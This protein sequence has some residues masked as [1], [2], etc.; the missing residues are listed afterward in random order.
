MDLKDNIALTPV[1]TS[2]VDG[3]AMSRTGIDNLPVKLLVEIFGYTSGV[4]GSFVDDQST[5][6][7]V[8]KLHNMAQVCRRW[9]EIIKDAAKLWAFVMDRT[10][11]YASLVLKQSQ[12]HAFSLSITSCP[13][14]M[15]LYTAVLSHSH[16]WIQADIRLT[17]PNQE[18]SH[19]LEAVSA[20]MLWHLK[21]VSPAWNKNTVIT[22]DLFLD[23]P[24][25]LTSLTLVGISI[26]RWN[27]PIFG[28]HLHSLTIAHTYTSGPTCE[29]LVGIFRACPTLEYLD[30]NFI[31][32]SG[33]TSRLLV[34]DFPVQ[35]HL[36]HTLLLSQVLSNGVMEIT[37][38]AEIPHCRNYSV[39]RCR[40]K[41]RSIILPA[42]TGQIHKP[43]EVCI[44]SSR[45]LEVHLK[46]SC[47]HIIC[48]GIQSPS[49]NF[50]LKLG[51]IRSYMQVIEWLDGMLLVRRPPLSPVLIDVHL[52]LIQPYPSTSDLLHLSDVQSLTI[53]DPFGRTCQLIEALSIP[54]D[55]K[56][57][58]GGWMWLGLREMNVR[59]FK[60]PERT[61]FHMVKMRTE[62][63][64]HQKE[65]KGTSGVAM[66]EWLEVGKGV[67]LVEDFEE[68]RAI[69][70]HVILT[71]SDI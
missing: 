29:D 6:S 61:L 56:E 10:P 58:N 44:A 12:S 31:I 39:F 51:E 62:V 26:R 71:E 50:N 22:L 17:H 66:L 25:K 27:S 28:Y 36:L 5:S 67:F 2:L 35:L 7:Y 60:D 45:S 69:L 64:L 4:Y 18:A 65:T 3:H 20:P 46:N 13:L 55:P 21:L 63:A 32:F 38:M 52:Y 34:R 11:T 1:T 9:L 49:S 8:S 59:A 37:R 40:R 70:G 53:S 48:H 43:F 47:I 54:T 23:Q 15:S 24:P 42:I 30:L 19:M 14:D 68:V 57:G 33:G 16:R 41:L